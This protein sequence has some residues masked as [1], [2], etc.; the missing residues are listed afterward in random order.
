[1]FFGFLLTMVCF[2]TYRPQVALVV[3]VSTY[4]LFIGLVLYLI[5]ALSDLFQGGMGVDPITF[6]HIVEKMRAELSQ[7]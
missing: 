5:L 6:E 1:V 2:G 3:L 4:T 7:D